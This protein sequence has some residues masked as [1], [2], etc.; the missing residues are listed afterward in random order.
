MAVND[1]RPFVLKEYVVLFCESIP[2]LHHPTI[3][4]LKKKEINTI[5]TKGKP[6]VNPVLAG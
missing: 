3:T 1:S 5:S 4:P 6:S 2:S